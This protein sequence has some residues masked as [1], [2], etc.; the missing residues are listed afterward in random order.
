[1]LASIVGIAG[2][3]RDSSE[4]RGD[5]DRGGDAPAKEL[6]HCESE[7]SLSSSPRIL[8]TRERRIVVSSPLVPAWS[9]SCI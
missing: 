7:G 3:A 9:R 6:A 1:L 4:E 5:R 2:H 8:A